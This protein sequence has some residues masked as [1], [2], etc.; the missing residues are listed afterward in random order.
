MHQQWQLLCC[1]QCSGGSNDDI[2]AKK[3]SLIEAEWP[4]TERCIVI[5]ALIYVQTL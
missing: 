2:L 4:E 3:R 1:G 5:L